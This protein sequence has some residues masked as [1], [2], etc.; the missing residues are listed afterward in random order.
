MY[1]LPGVRDIGACFRVHANK[2][3]YI[4]GDALVYGTFNN[5]KM[6]SDGHNIRIYGHG[7]L[8]GERIPHPDCDIP[9]ALEK[10][11]WKYKPIDIRVHTILRLRGLQL[12]ILLCIL[13]C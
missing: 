2:S 13:S 7:T 5:E 10:D 1:F 4:P 11:Y 8:S 6:G 3:Y 9:V 12:L